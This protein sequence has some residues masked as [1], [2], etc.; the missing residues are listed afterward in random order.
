MMKN[1]KLGYIQFD[2]KFGDK[3]ANLKKI[4]ELVVKASKADLLVLPEMCTTGYMMNSYEEAESLSEETNGN[5]VSELI[6]IAKINDVY[7]IVGMPEKERGQ[8]FI[9][10][11]VVGPEGLIAKHQKSH[12]FMKD[13]LYFTPG[14]TK[15]IV[16]EINGTKIGLGVCYDYMFPEFWRKLALEGAEVFVNTANFVYDYGFKMMQARA[17]E[18]GVF[19]IT[20]NRVGAERGTTFRGGSEIVDNRGNV[21]KKAGDEEEIFV[22]EIDAKKS[23]IKQWN[24]YNDL[25]KDR[26][27]DL[28]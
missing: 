17:I 16:F 15:P 5:I 23:R 22:I 2:P 1:M 21:Q 9:T 8:I 28:Y 20:V 24:E 18:N 19:S 6:K 26:R 7:L 10:S 25:F 13:K 12:L 11:V 14:N 27:I 3:E 4:G